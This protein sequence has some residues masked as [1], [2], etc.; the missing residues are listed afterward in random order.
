MELLFN[1]NPAILVPALRTVGNI[2]TGNDSQVRMT[3]D[4]T[5]IFT[6]Y[7][8]ILLLNRNGLAV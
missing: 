6:Y 3:F 7:S 5:P 1:P 8:D 2:V 4:H